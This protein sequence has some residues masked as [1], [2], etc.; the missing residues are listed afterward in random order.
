MSITSTNNALICNYI[1]KTVSIYLTI[2]Q[3]AIAIKTHEK[4]AYNLAPIVCLFHY[5]SLDFAYFQ[6]PTHTLLIN[7]TYRSFGICQ[8]RDMYPPIYPNNIAHILTI[9]NEKA[10]L[11][12]LFSC[13]SLLGKILF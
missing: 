3:F 9:S 11:I 7:I 6:Q 12:Y 8:I 2:V 4:G 13:I 10:D 1:S 5:F